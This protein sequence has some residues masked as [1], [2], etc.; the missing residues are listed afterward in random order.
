MNADLKDQEKIRFREFRR[1]VSLF[2]KI[3]IIWSFGI[4]P[5]LPPEIFSILISTSE[6]IL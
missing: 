2:K 5:P 6:R 1:N 3:Q 4:R